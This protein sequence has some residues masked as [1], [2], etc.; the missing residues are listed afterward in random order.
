M[1]QASGLVAQE[2]ADSRAEKLESDSRLQH[3]YGLA[4]QELSVS[5]TEKSEV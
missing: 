3:A 1:Q 5:R 4:E 2:L